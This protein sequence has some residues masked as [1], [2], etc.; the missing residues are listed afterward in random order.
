MLWLAPLAITGFEWLH[1]QTDASYPWLTSGY[2]LTQT[3]WGQLAEFGGVYGLTL[4][5]ASVNALLTY[6]LMLGRGRRQSWIIPVS[7]VAVLSA[8]LVVGL[9]RQHEFVGEHLY[10]ADGSKL[11]AVVVQPN[12]DPWDKWNDV[13]VQVA[14]LRHVTDSAC[15]DL[16]NAV[17]FWPETAI[18]YAIRQPVYGQDWEELQAWVDSSGNSL[19]TGYADWYQYPPGTA[20][21]SARSS[22][23]DP[24]YRYDTFNAAMLLMPRRI[25]GMQDHS[26]PVHRKTML[27]PLAER[28]PFADQLSFAMSWIEWGVGISAWGKGSQREPLPYGSN[29][30]IGMIICIESIYPEVSRDLVNHGA[31]VLSVITN[32]AWYNG[33]WGPDQHFNIARMRAIEMRRPVVRCAN[34]GVSGFI[35][36]DGSAPARLPVTKRTAL[37]ANVSGNSYRTVYAVA[38]DVVPPL[39]LAISIV[40]LVA[41]RFPSLVRKLSAHSE[42]NPSATP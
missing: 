5:L 38:G 32:D 28:L 8:L 26:I 39:G 9:V 16:E 3:P 34:S 24:S 35:E 41:A 11:R 14:I 12:E 17:V 13:R 19:I 42:Q 37:V 22:R 7:T 30:R 15:L 20:P 29:A 36:P 23:T 2:Q 21:P 33:T 31:N 6:W 1:G 27:T 10:G 18:P 4:L 25:G 40:L